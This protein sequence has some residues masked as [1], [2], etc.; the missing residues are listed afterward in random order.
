MKFLFAIL[1]K[2]PRIYPNIIK[3]LDVQT[4]IFVCEGPTPLLVLPIFTEINC[5]RY[6]ISYAICSNM[7]MT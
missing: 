4:K 5:N 6:C 2:G 1:E 7:T 3:I